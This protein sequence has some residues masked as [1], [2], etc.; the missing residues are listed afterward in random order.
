M[1]QAQKKR[2]KVLA[3]IVG[4]F[5]AFMITIGVLG[6]WIVYPTS[7]H[8]DV[9]RQTY[10]VVEKNGGAFNFQAYDSP[11]YKKLTENKE[12]KYST[13]TQFIVTLA[14]MA[15]TIVVVG[16][17]YNYIRKNNISVSKRAVGLTAVLTAIGNMIAYVVIVYPTSFFTG[18]P[19]LYD[20]IF[21]LGLI[22]IGVATF[23][24]DF[25][26]A[27]LYEIVYNKRH[28]FIVE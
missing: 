6:T 3:S 14:Q 16:S 5:T 27:S 9:A 17:I 19:V 8:R 7:Q 15:V 12:T 21:L 1:K 2:Y 4:I 10:Q 20:T 11:E 22:G 26:I 18:I 25:I 28:S 13:D 23:I 24:V